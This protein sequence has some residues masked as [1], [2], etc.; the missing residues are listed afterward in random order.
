MSWN[1]RGH[2][3][4]KWVGE[5]SLTAHWAQEMNMFHFAY[6]GVWGAAGYGVGLV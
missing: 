4:M 3:Q 1:Q 6:M 5:G 2:L